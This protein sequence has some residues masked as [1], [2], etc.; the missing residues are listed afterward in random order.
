MEKLE[1]LYEGSSKKLFNT[2][3]P[4]LLLV[5]FKDDRGQ[6]GEEGRMMG[7]GAANN[8]MTNYIFRFLEQKGVPTHYVQELSDTQTVVKKAEMFPLKVVIRNVAAGGFCKKL[9]IEEGLPL[10]WPTL[11]LLYKT[12]VP[13]DSM[14]N[15]Y[16]A[17]AVGAA[18]REELDRITELAFLINDQLRGLFSKMDLT[19]VDV[20][21]EFGRYKGQIIL[22]DEISP[23]TCRLWDGSTMEQLGCDLFAPP[24]RKMEEIYT[25]VLKYFGI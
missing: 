5:D 11:E 25:E 20:G 16:Y 13:I 18:T 3:D 19:L 8:R 10:S 17:I 12:S 9:G 7:R 21:L 1:L 2:E 23:D 4:D 14:I 15:D 24:G 6:L 22:A